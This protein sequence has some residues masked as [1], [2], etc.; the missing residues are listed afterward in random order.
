MIA[1]DSAA[2]FSGSK[3]AEAVANSLASRINTYLNE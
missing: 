1:E 2:Y 3:S